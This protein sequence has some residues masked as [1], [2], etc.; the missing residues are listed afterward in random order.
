MISKNK[1]YLVPEMI[2]PELAQVLENGIGKIPVPTLKEAI[3]G[4]ERHTKLFQIWCHSPRVHSDSLGLCNHSFCAVV[5]DYV[6]RS[7]TTMLLECPKCRTAYALTIEMIEGE[8]L[9]LLSAKVVNL[10]R[11]SQYFMDVTLDGEKDMWIKIHEK[12]S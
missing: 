7:R 9:K 8:P 6:G 2:E 1:N 12:K 10:N 11:A 4:D 5:G 3:L